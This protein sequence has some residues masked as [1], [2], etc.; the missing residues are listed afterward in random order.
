VLQQKCIEPL[1]ESKSDYQIYSLLAERLGIKERYTEGRDDLEWAKRMYEV[2]DLPKVMTWRQFQ[3]KGYYIVPVPKNYEYKPA[4]RW[5]AED[6]PKDNPDWGPNLVD[7]PLNDGKG[8]ATPTG[9]IEFE[10]Q[11]LVRYDPN[12]DERPPVPH[13]IPSWEGHTTTDLVG[14]FPLQLVTPHPRFSFHSQ[15]D[16]KD[17]WN[18]E[19]P[20]H[21]REKDGYRYWVIRLNPK[22][23]KARGLA[24]GDLVKV[25]NDRGTI[26][27]ILTVTARMREGVAH[28]YSSGG[29]YD[30]MGEPGDP[31]T[32]DKGGT[33]N[34]LTS[35]RFNSRNT[36]GMAPGSCLVEVAKWEGGR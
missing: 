20:H 27:C 29:G 23:A 4:F 1:G 5:Y 7:R 18:D 17:M 28:S 31:K 33:I 32:V 12:D 36:S 6:R 25:F 3:K 22:D 24:D 2:S 13:Y 35:S 11:S 14:K 15:F 26:L 34:Q 16:A 9:K 21:R 19:I 8:L 30:P 10:S